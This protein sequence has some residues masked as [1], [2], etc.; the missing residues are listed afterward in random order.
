MTEEKIAI[1]L[2]FDYKIPKKKASGG[3]CQSTSCGDDDLS[4]YNPLKPVI[5]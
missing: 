5:V 2:A 1:E 4:N 3:K